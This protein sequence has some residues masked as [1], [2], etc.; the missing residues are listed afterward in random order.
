MLDVEQSLNPFQHVSTEAA[1]QF[2][3]QET[4]SE[5]WKFA[6]VRNPWDRYVSLYEHLYYSPHAP[7]PK[8]NSNPGGA[9][10][11]SFDEWVY[12]VKNKFINAN[13]SEHP[14]LRW[15]NGVDTVFQFED[16]ATFL[17]LISKRIGV[18]LTD[19]RSNTSTKQ[20]ASYA[21]YYKKKATIDTVAELD[22]AVIERF[23][24]TFGS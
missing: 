17:P 5:Y 9:A 15:I 11:Y 10:L 13:P 12:L 3:F 6:F 24:Y 21:D 14:Q 19:L 23:G 18:E 4:W 2:L 1:K 8:S 7:K 20:F 16:R 22:K